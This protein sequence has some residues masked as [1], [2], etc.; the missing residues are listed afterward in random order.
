MGNEVIPEVKT[1]YAASRDFLMQFK[2]KCLTNTGTGADF[3][4]NNNLRIIIQIIYN[5][6]CT[7]IRQIHKT[8][9]SCLNSILGQLLCCIHSILKHGTIGYKYNIFTLPVA[10]YSARQVFPVRVRICAFRTP[11]IAN[12][13][14]PSVFIDCPMQHI[15]LL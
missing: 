15:L 4:H 14:R 13:N 7:K 3:F 9:N 8:Q 11:W 2:C 10:L 1:S 12:G 6:F 5:L